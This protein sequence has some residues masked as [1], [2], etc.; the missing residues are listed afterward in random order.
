M[1]LEVYKETFGVCRDT[2]F[3][4]LVGVSIRNIVYIGVP[5]NL[6]KLPVETASFGPRV[7]KRGGSELGYRSQGYGLQGS[8]FGVRI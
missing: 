3:I 6:W 7:W 2:D 5:P 1:Y 8:V 4:T